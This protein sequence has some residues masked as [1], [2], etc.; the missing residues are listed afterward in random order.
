MCAVKPTPVITIV[1]TIVSQAS[2]GHFHPC[3]HSVHNPFQ[4]LVWKPVDHGGP[5]MKRQL[6]AVTTNP[7]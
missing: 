5:G 4:L 1:A 2:L 3:P 7:P 6:V